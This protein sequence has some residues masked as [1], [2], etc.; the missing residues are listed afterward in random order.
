MRAGP[1]PAALPLAIDLRDLPVV[2]VGAGRVAAGKVSALLAAGARVTVV[3]PQA[4]E[5]VQA[6]CGS[7]T[8]RW[9]PRGYR[10]QDLDGAVLVI[11]ATD[12]PA[13]NARVAADAAA[14]STLCVR[15]D[16]GGTA[17]FAAVLRR[18]P[19]TVAVSTGGAAPALARRLRDQL[20]SAVGAEYG[21]LADLLGQLRADPKVQTALAALPAEARAA[22]WRAILDTDILSLLR[23]GEQTTA[24][25]VATACLFSS[26]D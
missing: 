18:G 17:E 9:L 24:R 20:A 1:S 6:L 5:R 23:D 10:D 22:K 12:D 25:E 8:L 14:Q 11:A 13:T 16:G 3:A 4:D 2:C 15:V 19:V 7:Q 26:S 21:L